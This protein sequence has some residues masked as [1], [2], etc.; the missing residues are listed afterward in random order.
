MRLCSA[1]KVD[2]ELAEGDLIISYKIA[3]LFHK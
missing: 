2:T 1:S 3:K